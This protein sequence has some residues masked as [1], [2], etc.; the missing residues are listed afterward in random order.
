M[1]TACSLKPSIWEWWHWEEDSQWLGSSSTLG[2][3]QRAC[4]KVCLIWKFSRGDWRTA[5]LPGNTKWRTNCYRLCSSI[6]NAHFKEFWILILQYNNSLRAPW[7]RCATLEPKSKHGSKESWIPPNGHKSR[8]IENS[9]N[10]YTTKI[11][12]GRDHN[13]FIFS[14]MIIRSIL[15][16]NTP[17]PHPFTTPLSNSPVGPARNGL[18][19]RG[20]WKMTHRLQDISF[21]NSLLYFKFLLY[22]IP[23]KLFNKKLLQKRTKISETKT[24]RV[25]YFPQ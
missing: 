23:L 18:R 12:T 7:K 21:K 3:W 6:K 10:R 9:I 16:Y 8:L 25:Q 5:F 14:T 1:L 2:N 4:R 20:L 17:P 15:E 19:L 11:S 24:K 22:T 13:A